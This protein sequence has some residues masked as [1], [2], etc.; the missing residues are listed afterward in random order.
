MKPFVIT[1]NKKI[2]SLTVKICPK[3]FYD[4]SIEGEPHDALKLAR[5][6]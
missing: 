6:T 4:T 1:Q 3:N 2:K 5:F